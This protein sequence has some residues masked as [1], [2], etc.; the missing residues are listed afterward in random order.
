MRLRI[1]IPTVDR[2]EYELPP[3][4]CPACGNKTW[5]SH[6]WPSK[7]IRDTREDQVLAHRI[8]C[9][10]CHTT[11]RIYPRGVT[12]RKQSERVRGLSIMLWLLGLS[13]R[14]VMDVLTALGCR[15]SHALVYHNVQQAGEKVRQLKERRIGGR[16]VRV[17]AADCTRVRV[18]GENT[19]LLH[20]ADGETG[21]CL[22]IDIV[23]GED[24]ESLREAIEEIAG[25]VGA[26]VLLSDDA[27]PYKDVGDEL[28]LAH[29]LCHQ[30]VVPNTL[31]KLAQIAEQLESRL[32]RA[33][34]SGPGRKKIE[35]AIEHI[36]ELEQ[37]ILWGCPG[38][39]QRLD[40]LV[41][42]YE[43]EPLPKKG[44]RATPF[45]RLKLLTLR[46]GASWPRLTLA[47]IC[48]DK[49]GGRFIPKTNNVSEQGIGMN[50]KERYRTMRGYKSRVSLL[51]VVALTS[52]LR[53]EGDD[54]ALIRVLAA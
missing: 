38:S 51:R 54:Q 33:G 53:D 28:G 25:A 4:R 36:L 12:R 31:R 48:R 49:D 22:A 37:I 11:V 35:E 1:N 43:Q 20:L 45:A 27:D 21:L 34:Q 18:K 8:Q 50:I 2:A 40:E 23:P 15:L 13:Y 6:G 5:Q 19:I 10:A 47:E 46:L 24:V 17:L 44:Q 39:Q 26:E 42:V 3:E 9:T 41:Q 52:H 7:A 16:R 32:E 14:A 30:H 29:G